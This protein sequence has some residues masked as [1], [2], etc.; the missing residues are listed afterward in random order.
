MSFRVFGPDIISRLDGL[1]RLESVL[2]MDLSP[3][4][5][6]CCTLG[7]R[8]RLLLDDSGAFLRLADLSLTLHLLLSNHRSFRLGLHLDDALGLL[9]HVPRLL[10]VLDRLVGFVSALR[11]LED[12]ERIDC[13]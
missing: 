11:H 7:N 1:D 13:A 3:C 10:G 9:V 5:E 8:L 4:G 12:L 2:R 6:A